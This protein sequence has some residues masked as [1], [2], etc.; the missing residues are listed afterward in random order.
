MEIKII[1]EGN[2][3]IKKEDI[4]NAYNEINKYFKYELENFIIR[5]H[6]TRNDFDKQL[7]RKTLEWE[8]ANA[9]YNNEIDILHPEAF[10]KESSHEENE[11]IPILKH[12]I[13]H[14]LIDRL[15][16]NKKI[17]KW[18]DEG[19]S[20]YI[21]GQ[22]KNIL[23]NSF[24]IEENFCEKFGSPKGWDEHSNYYA[25]PTA[26]LF[27]CFLIKN[28]SLE[29]M[30]EFVLSLNKNYYYPDFKKKFKEKFN[31]DINELEKTFTKEINK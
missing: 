9:S 24:Y 6:E 1:Y 8:V 16:N 19:L 28:F 27:V 15:T 14:L 30:M 22:Y 31:T 7:K 18:L 5:I 3:P 2:S 21:S 26:S 29:K 11:F 13:S 4:I 10:T 25:Y 17:P 23:S 20:S 12:E